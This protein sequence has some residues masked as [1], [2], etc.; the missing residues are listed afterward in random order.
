LKFAKQKKS[1]IKGSCNHAKKSNEHIHTNLSVVS[2]IKI[3]VPY[4]DMLL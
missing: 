2:D 4:I 3:A 1:T